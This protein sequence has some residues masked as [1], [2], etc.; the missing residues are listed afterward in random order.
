MS[1]YK[2]HSIEEGDKVTTVSVLARNAKNALEINA[3]VKRI[4]VNY[5]VI[6]EN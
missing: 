6:K 1:E 3:L 5:N 4:K 2:I